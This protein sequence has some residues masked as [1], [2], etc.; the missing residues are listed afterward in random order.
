M[1]LS[2]IGVP[3]LHPTEDELIA[4]AAGQ[5]DV[6]RR[7]LLDAHLTY[8]SVC[9]EVHASF[10]T[11]GSRM[12]AAAPE[13]PAPDRLLDGLLARIDSE[14]ETLDPYAEL[15]LPAD[16]LATL[17]RSEKPLV[18]GSPDRWTDN[19]RV[20]CLLTDPRAQARLFLLEIPPGERIPRHEHLGHEHAL[21]LAGACHDEHT[22]L[23]PGDYYHYEPGTEHLP[24]ME[25]GEPCWIVVRVEKGVR[26]IA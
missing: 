18:F 14:K 7:I 5:L 10:T 12:L 8:C 11:A 15:P 20:A 25:P 23:E 16:L 19:S 24:I 1:A 9:R 17:P 13:E 26:F 3:Q 21:C 22:R 2:R 4:L 6:S